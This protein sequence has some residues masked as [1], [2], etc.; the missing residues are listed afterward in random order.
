MRST[1]VGRRSPNPTIQPSVRRAARRTAASE[2]APIQ[3]VGRGC[4]TGFGYTAMSS[5]SKNSPWNE[6]VSSVHAALHDLEA[7][8]HA[9]TRV[10]KSRLSAS[11]SYGR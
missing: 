3:I 6:N 4:C 7:L 8:R 9:A 10:W 5:K 2:L 1:A 11:Y